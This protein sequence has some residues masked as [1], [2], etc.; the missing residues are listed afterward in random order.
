MCVVVYS[1][2]KENILSLELVFKAVFDDELLA[3]EYLPVPHDTPHSSHVMDVV[4]E[5]QHQPATHTACKPGSNIVV[6]RG[7][8]EDGSFS[9]QQDTVLDRLPVCRCV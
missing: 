5:A 2:E 9:M 6:M 4:I 8:Y 3:L 1:H 7:P